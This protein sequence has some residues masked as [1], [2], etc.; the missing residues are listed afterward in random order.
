MRDHF[1]DEKIVK[2]A[3]EVVPVD[4]DELATEEKKKQ[5][6]RTE[7]LRKEKKVLREDKSFISK[8]DART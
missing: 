5:K 2:D 4:A 1:P 8:K 3:V 6:T 7:Q